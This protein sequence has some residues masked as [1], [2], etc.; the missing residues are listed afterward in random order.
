MERMEPEHIEG[1]E[2]PGFDNGD[3]PDIGQLKKSAYELSGIENE[4]Q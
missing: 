4:N 3:T 1:L 2:L